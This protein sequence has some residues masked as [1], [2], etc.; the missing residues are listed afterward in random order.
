MGKEALVEGKLIVKRPDADELL[1][2]RNGA[3]TY[4]EILAYAED[5]D[6]KISELYKIT[7]LPKRPNLQ[8]VAA[9]L[10]ETQQ[11]VWN[12]PTGKID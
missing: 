9:I 12:N 4:E 5:M 8:K 2:I 10:M 3:W 1:A 6:S 11:Y 7:S